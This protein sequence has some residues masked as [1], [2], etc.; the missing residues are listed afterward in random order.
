MGIARDWP[1]LVPP[2]IPN[3]ISP[4]PSPHPTLVTQEHPWRLWGCVLWPTG[5]DHVL[6]PARPLVDLYSRRYF[7]TVPYEE[8]KWRRR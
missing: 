6:P 2:L 7:L 5:A 4:G 3:L 8:C 1:L